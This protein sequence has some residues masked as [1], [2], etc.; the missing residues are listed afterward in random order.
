MTIALKSTFKERQLLLNQVPLKSFQNFQL[1]KRQIKIK[2]NIFLKF[3]Q[4]NVNLYKRRH[5]QNGLIHILLEQT[6]E[7]RICMKICE[8]V[9]N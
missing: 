9:K 6:N 1:T 2:F 8:M 5:L 4:L 3:K 7:F